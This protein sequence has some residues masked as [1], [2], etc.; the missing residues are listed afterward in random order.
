VLQVEENPDGGRTIIAPEE[1]G[2][3]VNAALVQQ[4]LDAG[5]AI[6]CVE[7]E[8]NTLSDDVAE[9][10]ECSVLCVPVFVRGRVGA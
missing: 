9:S 2:V 3:A 5:R 6:A 8:T 7:E 4:A 10:G 1:A